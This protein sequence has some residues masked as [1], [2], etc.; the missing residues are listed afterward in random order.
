MSY[1]GVFY[2]M[3]CPSKYHANSDIWE[4]KAPKETQAYLTKT[5][6]QARSKLN[7]L[8]IPY[9]GMRVAEPHQGGCPH[10]HMIL[11]MPKSCMNKANHV[12]RRYFSKENRVELVNRFKERGKYKAAY[13]NARQSWGY[14]KSKGFHAKEP[15]KSYFPSSPRFTAMLMD[16][17]KGGAA[18][19]IAKY[20]SKNIDGYNLNN[21]VD[22]ESGDHLQKSV[23]PVLAW[24]STW[25]IRQFQ[26][27]GAP[28]VTIYRELRRQRKAIEHEELEQVRK[29]AD[30]GRWINFVKLMGGM[31][32]GRSS[33]FKLFHEVTPF[34]ND[35][36]EVVKRVKGV[37]DEVTDNCLLTRLTSWTKQIKG[38]AEK[39][40]NEGQS[41]VSTA[42]QSWT[43]G[44][45]CTVGAIGAAEELKLIKLG[46]NKDQIKDLKQGKKIIFEDVIVKVVKGE[47]AILEGQA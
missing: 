30:E 28:S 7:R 18:S 4:G 39:L 41:F 11:F 20:I 9:F 37:I 5:W 1:V 27:Q 36:G 40:R 17:D 3:T 43:Y 31:C 2:T 34:G 29:A 24:A 23:N 10:W 25:G 19:Y 8:G 12:L 32:I 35:Y 33:R 47:L 13:N 26:F 38:T 42:H 6:S 46:F 21:H 44:N 16:P 22:E 45:N 15:H 14:K